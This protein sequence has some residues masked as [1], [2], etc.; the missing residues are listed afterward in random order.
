M[1]EVILITGGAGFIGSHLAKKLI[2]Q[3]KKVIIADSFLSG[4]DNLFSLGLSQSDF[5]LRQVDLANFSDAKKALEGVDTVFHMAARVGGISYVHGNKN[6]EAISMETNI[7]IDANVF[8]ACQEAGVKKIIY[9][10]SVSVYPMKKQESLGAVF[11]EDDFTVKILNSRFKI[12]DSTLD[13]DGG[14]GLAKALGEIELSMMEGIKVG[15]A[16]TFS[17]YGENESLGEKA[18]VLPRL[19]KNAIKYPEDE[20]V[21]WGDGAQTRDYIY[22]TDCAEALIKLAEAIENN[23]P[24]V[25]NVGAGVS[26]SIGELA[27]KIIAISGKDI[28]PVYLKEKPVGP[29]SRTADIS[30]AKEILGWVPK[31]SLDEGLEREYRWIEGKLKTV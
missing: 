22:V 21:I 19:I 27:E 30:R 9:S 31:V 2:E 23:S 25:V 7:A 6:T 26:V 10:S 3:G 17:A 8:R 15:I 18:H 20:M 4:M 13:L 29:M 14:Y 11:S 28:K 1:A 24:I 16:R 12:P 5:E